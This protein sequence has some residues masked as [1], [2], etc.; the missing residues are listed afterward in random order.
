MVSKNIL[1]DTTNIGTFKFFAYVFNDEEGKVGFGLFPNDGPCPLVYLLNVQGNKIKIFFNDDLIMRICEQSKFSTNERRELFRQFLDYASKMEKKA[2]RLVFR[3]SK[4][5][6]LAESR[7][8]VRYKR[9]Y[10]HY[11]NPMSFM[12]DHV[13]ANEPA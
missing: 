1:V 13:A 12:G 9:L 6:Y 10:I 4:M 8:M 3:D 7:E 11:K 2:A 5:S